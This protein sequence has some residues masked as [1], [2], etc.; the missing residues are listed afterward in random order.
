MAKYKIEFKKS[1]GKELEKLP[2]KYL[3]RI[4]RKIRLLEEN[5][6]PEGCE[7]L[8]DRDRYRIRQGNY[9]VVFEIDDKEKKLIIYKI[10]DRKEIYRT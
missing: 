6:R 3:K 8:T 10:G 2:Q 9:R 7:K 5:P 4:I 1:A